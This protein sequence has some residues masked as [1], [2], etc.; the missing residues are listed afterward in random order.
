VL[1]N[2]PNSGLN[3]RAFDD[4]TFGS[5]I[6]SLMQLLDSKCLN[7][8]LHLSG[9]KILRKI[10]EVENKDHL[11]P[12]AEWDTDDWDKYKTMIEFK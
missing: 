2:L 4:V 9:I 11:T 8:H 3:P 12:A 5:V 7:K 10:V 1:K 6:T